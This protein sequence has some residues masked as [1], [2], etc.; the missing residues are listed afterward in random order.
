MW[1][2]L[3][4]A[5]CLFAGLGS[6]CNSSSKPKPKKQKSKNCVSVFCGRSFEESSCDER[7][8]R[9]EK[10]AF[11][12]CESDGNLGLTWLEVNECEVSL[13]F[14]CSNNTISCSY[15][16]CL[17]MLVCRCR[18]LMTS[19]HLMLTLMVT[20]LLMSG[21]RSL[22]AKKKDLC[23]NNLKQ[24]TLLKINLWK[25]FLTFSEISLFIQN[26]FSQLIQKVLKS[27]QFQI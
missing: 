22:G 27:I 24:Q 7:I 11:V 19:K 18:H 8:V 25:W 15:R 16:K 3:L 2:S 6:P 21:L 14:I 9:L 10:G 4:I 17:K 26:I 23:L 1:T 12:A 20:S 13:N 5:L